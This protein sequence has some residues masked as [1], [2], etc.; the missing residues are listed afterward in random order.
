MRIERCKA[1]DFMS[2]YPAACGGGV[3]LNGDYT[4]LETA[5]TKY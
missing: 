1:G 5:S 4:N 3:Y 2:K